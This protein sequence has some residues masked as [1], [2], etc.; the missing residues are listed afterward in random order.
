M[1]SRFRI[2]PCFILVRMLLTVA[3]LFITVS[4]ISARPSVSGES[5]MKRTLFS[6][7]VL[8]IETDSIEIA[9]TLAIDTTIFVDD[10]RFPRR[11]FGSL[12]YTGHSLKQGLD[13]FDS[14]RIESLS[15]VT[16]WIE[17]RK[18]LEYMMNSIKD[19][20]MFGN[21]AIVRY[22]E[23]LLPEPPKVYHA[24]VDPSKAQISIRESG[25]DRSKVTDA[26][27]SVAI[28]KKHWLKVFDSSLHFS[29]AYNS[30]NWYQG[31]NNNLNMLLNASYNV[32][33]NQAFHPDILFD[34]TIRYKLAMNN[35]PEDTLRDY[36]ISED[37]FQINT[38]F[39]IKAAK[40]WYYSVTA[41]FKTQLL[42]NYRT[43]SRDLKAS[44]LSPGELNVGLGM[45]YNYANAKKTF[46]FNASIAPLSYNMKICTNKDI[47]ET[48]FGIERGHTTANQYGSN[49]ECK[50]EWKMTHN[51]TYN[52][53]L[54]VFS[55]Y[56]YIQGDWEHTL[57]C[58]INRYLTTQ[59][60]V[61]LRYDSQTAAVDDS[62][63]HKLQ[64]KEI[65]SFGFAYK[66]ATV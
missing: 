46:S 65:L 28:D 16:R 43:N 19:S 51:I 40:R 62:K 15:P 4:E 5:K 17:R 13:P 3:I 48:S 11:F 41:M 34:N 6:E 12:V 55:D 22:N 37:L 18:R 9:D 30:P 57:S 33:L 24:V 26:P 64:L 52:S 66:F 54:F 39:G 56:S 58:A 61:H 38:N 10:L 2:H 8:D 7:S 35:A 27:K 50:L 32:K 49:A 47:D 29:Q 1:L 20:V 60:Y 31:G 59:I 36:S 23:S 14:G 42:N 63:W 53:R 45:T 44:F 21:P 25:I